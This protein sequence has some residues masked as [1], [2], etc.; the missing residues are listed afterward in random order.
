M[1]GVVTSGEIQPVSGLVQGNNQDDKP[2]SEMSTQFPVELWTTI[3]SYL[4]FENLQK[5]SILVCKHWFCMIRNN[6]SLGTIQLRRG[7]IFTIFDPFLPWAF[8]QNAYEGDFWSL[9][10]V[11]F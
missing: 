6:P 3:L 8:Q 4:D 2:A 10:T 5:K 1:D 9:C 11:T 7:Q